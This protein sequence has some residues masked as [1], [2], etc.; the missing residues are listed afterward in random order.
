[1]RDGLHAVPHPTTAF[2][3]NRIAHPG[4]TATACGTLPCPL[5]DVYDNPLSATRSHQ[6]YSVVKVHHACSGLHASEGMAPIGDC[7]PPR[8]RP[9]H[10][11]DKQALYL[12]LVLYR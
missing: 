10:A 7:S 5:T 8:P 6:P 9:R 4:V 11:R 1:M 2:A 12:Q 3:A